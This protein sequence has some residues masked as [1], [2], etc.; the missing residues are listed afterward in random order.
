MVACPGEVIG[1]LL[2]TRLM[3]NRRVGIGRAARWLGGVFAPRPMHLV[4]VLRFRIIRFHLLVADRPGGRNTVVMA[5]FAEIFL[6]LAVEGSS[7]EFGRPPP[8]K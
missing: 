4:Q 7:V 5:Q 8:T 2:D 1:Q 6:A 3:G